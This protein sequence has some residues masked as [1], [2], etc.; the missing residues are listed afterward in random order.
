MERLNYSRAP[1][2]R[3][4][5]LLDFEEQHHYQGYEHYNGAQ[6]RASSG[7]QTK[8]LRDVIYCTDALAIIALM[9]H[10]S[11]DH[12]VWLA[13]LIGV[14]EIGVIYQTTLWLHGKR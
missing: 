9:V 4:A 3:F 10:A 6:C 8:A 14:F 2:K 13:I 11:L 1:T 7:S 5:Y 12:L